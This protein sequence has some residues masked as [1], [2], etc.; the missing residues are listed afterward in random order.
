MDNLPLNYSK[1]FHQALM[2]NSLKQETTAL[3]LNVSCPLFFLTYRNLLQDLDCFCKNTNKFY[4]VLTLRQKNHLMP[5]VT[6]VGRSCDK[7]SEYIKEYIDRK[8][9]R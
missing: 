9:L 3:S 5:V 2:V 4:F 1:L 7:A 8:P 6:L